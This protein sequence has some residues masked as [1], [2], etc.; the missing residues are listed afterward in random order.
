MGASLPR[1]IILSI[2]IL[3][4]WFVELPATEGIPDLVWVITCTAT[5]FVP[6]KSVFFI[7][8]LTGIP[9]SILA[10]SW[11]AVLSP[12]LLILYITVTLAC[13]CLSG[14]LFV[15]ISS[16][17]PMRFVSILLG[18]LGIMGF[19]AFRLN[20]PKIGLVYFSASLIISV[21]TITHN[22]RLNSLPTRMISATMISYVVWISSIHL[23]RLDPLVMTSFLQFTEKYLLTPY[24]VIL[25][26][27]LIVGHLI[28][29]VQE[30]LRPARS[31]Q[32][33]D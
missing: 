4:A 22:R 9:G 25:L 29:F 1:R 6:L 13:L 11:G 14:F 8:L 17:S 10:R 18:I 26:E 2:V 3:G 31:G 5:L 33:S 28:V 7:T 23:F 15:R 21:L 20:N 32:N 12:A 19:F 30:S 24:P 27:I 16:I